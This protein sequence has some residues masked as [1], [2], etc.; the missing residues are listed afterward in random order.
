MIQGAIMTQL[1]RRV[2]PRFAVQLP[3]KLTLANGQNIDATVVNLSLS[4]LQLQ[5]DNQ[6]VPTLMP[7]QSREFQLDT[8]PLTINIAL[9]NEIDEVEIKLGLVY[10]RRVSMQESLIGCRF[11]AFYQ[12]SA[13]MLERFIKSI[14]ATTSPIEDDKAMPNLFLT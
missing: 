11:E 14:R 3:A 7:N 13:S 8:I 2:A 9:P 1:D 5:V 4:G 10:L 12:K 6:T